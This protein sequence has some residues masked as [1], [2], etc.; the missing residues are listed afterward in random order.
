MPRPETPVLNRPLKETMAAGP[1]GTAG[2]QSEWLVI[3]GKNGNIRPVDV[4]G[5]DQPAAVSKLGELS[6]TSTHGATDIRAAATDGGATCPSSFCDS[7]GGGCSP[8]K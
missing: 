7:C 4:K 8:N 3:A 2:K 5:A 6:V 1:K